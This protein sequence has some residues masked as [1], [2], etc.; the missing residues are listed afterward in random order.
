MAKE[1][2]YQPAAH[3]L[4]ERH[5]AWVNVLIA[6]RASQSG[7]S[8]A[9]IDDARQEGWFW[10]MEGIVRYDTLEGARPK[11]CR[12]RTFLYAVIGSRV[13]DFARGIWRRQGL[14]EHASGIPDPAD[15]PP[16]AIQLA[17]PRADDCHGDPVAALIWQEALDRLQ[18]ALDCLHKEARDFWQRLASG[19]ALRDIARERGI[20]YQQARGRRQRLL[21]R[22]RAQLRDGRKPPAK[23]VGKKRC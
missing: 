6:R 21:A 18:S 15:I 19:M 20:S 14:F 8:A 1:C 17:W 13:I 23:K 3:A 12:F 2:D 22:L 9:D 11:G 10:M 4:F 5:H 16:G 7:L